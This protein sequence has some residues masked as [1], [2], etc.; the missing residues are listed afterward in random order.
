M[1]ECA[2][3]ALPAAWRPDGCTNAEAVVWGGGALYIV[4]NLV[5]G[6]ICVFL[7]KPILS[8]SECVVLEKILVNPQMWHNINILEKHLKEVC[9]QTQK[10]SK[11]FLYI[12]PATFNLSCCCVA[13]Q[14]ED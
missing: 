12:V 1:Q 6:F 11:R 9:N 10:S 13:K 7:S 3:S 14:L 2:D 8:G 5:L 4:C